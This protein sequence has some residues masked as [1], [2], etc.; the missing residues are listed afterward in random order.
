MM[1]QGLHVWLAVTI[2]APMCYDRG[3][4]SSSYNINN[5]TADLPS[6]PRQSCLA[7][8]DWL[9]M[10]ETSVIGPQRAAV[11]IPY[12]LYEIYVTY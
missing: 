7:F 11:N 10:D 8:T 6:S 4:Y 9:M 2:S 12:V 5:S 3:M 1:L